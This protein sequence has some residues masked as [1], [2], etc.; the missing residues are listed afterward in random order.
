[1]AKAGINHI[2]FI[3]DGNGRW[4]QARGLSRLD[5]HKEGANTLRTVVETLIEQNVPVASFYAF[6]SE[7]WGRPKAEVEGLML[8]LKNYLTSEVDKLAEKG[9]KLTFV[10]D[11][12]K[13]GKL[14]SSILA[15]MD[16]AEEKT[17]DGTA[18]HLNI[19]INY[20]GQ[21][22]IARA[23]QK[24]V[25]AGEGVITPKAIESQLDTAGQPMPDLCIRTGGEQRLSNFMLWQLSYAELFFS[26]SY[27]PAFSKEEL[28]QIIQDFSGRQRR[29]GKLP[30]NQ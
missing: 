29:F 5:G 11:R 1:L 12:T 10:G 20:G 22:E 19:C 26:K 16:K 4:A 17:K 25:D 13:G 21:D 14:S 15:L 8:L 23:V 9:A 27:W 7:N 24:L 30:E 18:I 28:T 2:A 3:M 6:S